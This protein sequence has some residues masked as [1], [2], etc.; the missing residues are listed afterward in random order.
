M[1]WN[2]NNKKFEVE[3]TSYLEHPHDKWINTNLTSI[4]LG[5]KRL[6]EE[7]LN[8]LVD[9]IEKIFLAFNEINHFIP[10]INLYIREY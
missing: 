10:E 2:Y 8:I 7:E 9:E 5:E 1:V 4:S 6:L 3:Y